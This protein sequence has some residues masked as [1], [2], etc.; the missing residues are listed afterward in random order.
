MT[1]TID[2]STTTTDTE[3]MPTRTTR[4]AIE[5]TVW[6]TVFGFLGWTMSN[7]WLWRAVGGDAGQGHY[8]DVPLAVVAIILAVVFAALA[9][10]ALIASRRN[11]RQHSTSHGL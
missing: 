3:V 8:F 4:L 10:G 11:A 7:G 9:V 5:F 1:A 6:A 2:R